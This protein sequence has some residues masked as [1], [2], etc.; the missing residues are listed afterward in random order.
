[1]LSRLAGKGPILFHVETRLGRWGEEWATRVKS[2]RI[3]ESAVI[4]P[5]RWLLRV[6]RAPSVIWSTPFCRLS[7][8]RMVEKD[9]GLTVLIG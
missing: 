4:E 8:V 5:V 2:K 6:V 1:M 9:C 7:R 3:S